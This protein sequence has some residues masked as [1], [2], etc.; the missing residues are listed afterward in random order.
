MDSDIWDKR[1]L[2]AILKSIVTTFLLVVVFLV[3]YFVYYMVRFE[4]IYRPFK[5]LQYVTFYTNI[6]ILFAFVSLYFVV[7]AK[8]DFIDF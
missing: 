5:I 4:T 7:K 2:N 8:Q 3:C 1:Y 6:L